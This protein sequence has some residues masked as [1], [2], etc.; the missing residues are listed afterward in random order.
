M[1]FFYFFDLGGGELIAAF[2]AFV[3]G[4]AFEPLPIYFMFCGEGVEVAPEVGVFDRLFFLGFPAVAFPVFD[5]GG[6]AVFD[7]VGIGVEGDFA[8]FFED[9]QGF[10][11]GLKF[12]AVV[13]GGG[14]AAADFQFVR[15]AGE[16]GG[17]A[18]GTWVAV[19]AAVGVDGDLM[20]C[21][22]EDREKF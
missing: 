20:H 12:H 17:P 3:A 2:V 4:V 5:P 18:A 15:A 6:D 19:A 7:V 8:G 22:R 11:G 10:D 1:G 16:D 13:G 21:G 9:F 14:S